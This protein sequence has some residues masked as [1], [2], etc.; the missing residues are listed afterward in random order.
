MDSYRDWGHAKDYVRSMH[1]II[2]HSE[3][4]EFVIATGK[5]H[6]V[7]ELCQYVFSRLDLDYKDYVVQN[8]KYLRPEEL[9]YL[10]GNA[11]K[12]KTI[13]NWEPKY[14]FEQLLDEMI[15]HWQR[16]YT[17]DNNLSTFQC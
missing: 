17:D 8:E 3:P 7:R 14:T 16:I 15:E 13:L 1:M 11:T 9:K 10:K 12:A 2:N 4:D 6:S 5:A